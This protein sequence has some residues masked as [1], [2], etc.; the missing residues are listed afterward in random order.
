M[1]PGPWQRRARRARRP[2]GPWRQRRAAER[3][4]RARRA[5]GARQAPE[6]RG[7]AQP[8]S[9]PPR[10]LQPWATPRTVRRG[11]C[12]LPPRRG[13]RGG[14]ALGGAGDAWTMRESGSAHPAPLPHRGCPFPV[15]TPDD[16]NLS[17]AP[18]RCLRRAA[19]SRPGQPAPQTARGARVPVCGSATL[20]P[21][22]WCPR[23]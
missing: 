20:G 16:D 13:R 6:A 19:V 9:R 23:W 8:T 5:P 7:L 17:A 11:E 15:P 4:R 10:G 21:C 2:G 22:P 18:A 14:G 1:E 12:Q 3:Q